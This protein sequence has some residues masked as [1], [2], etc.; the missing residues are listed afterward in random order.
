MRRA[1]LFCLLICGC[2]PSSAPPRAAKPAESSRGFRPPTVERVKRILFPRMQIPT[3]TL[4]AGMCCARQ[5]GE[6]FRVWYTGNCAGGFHIGWA[7]FNKDWKNIAEPEKPC[8]TPR[9]K[10]DFDSS[11][12]FMPCVVDPGAGDLRMYYAAHAEGPFPGPGSSAGVAISRDGGKTW[13]K[14][15]QTLAAT[16]DDAS[17]VGTHCVWQDSDGWRMIYTHIMPVDADGEKR[18]FLKF[19]TSNDG[20]QWERPSDNVALD[21]PTTSSTRPCVWKHGDRYFMTYTS[22]RR[23][24]SGY[25]I[26]FA[27]SD[28]GRKFTDRGQIL[29]VNRESEWDNEMVCYAWVLP[30]QDL[31]FY[32]GNN[33]GS[34]GLGVARLKFE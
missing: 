15:R 7:D 33:Y 27:D 20:F 23:D 3:R 11:A 5:Q 6:G 1:A 13:E 18:Y 28:D 17:G 26:R 4:Q 14:R 9:S 10:G 25:R 30:E 8:L 29:D 21:I 31:L 34:K 22:R 16:G 24:Y 12:V 2:L 19:A 32:T